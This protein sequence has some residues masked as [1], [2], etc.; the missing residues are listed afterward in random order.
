[1][2]ADPQVAFGAVIGD[3]S[4]EDQEFVD[5]F[6][7]GAHVEE[8][9]EP[10][11]LPGP[12]GRVGEPD[13][14]VGDR[15]G[16]RPGAGR[17]VLDDGGAGEGGS[18]RW[19]VVD[20]DAGEDAGQV[21]LGEVLGA[22]GRGVG[23]EPRPAAQGADRVLAGGQQPAGGG[24]AANRN[25]H[26]D[27]E[28]RPDEREGANQ[29]PLLS[30]DRPE[31]RQARQGEGAELRAGE[32]EEPADAVLGVVGVDSHR[33]APSRRGSDD[34]DSGFAGADLTGRNTGACWC[35]SGASGGS[36]GRG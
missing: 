17:L 36:R 30:V 28:E 35:S 9:S 7:T 26:K 6:G 11:A 29:R 8:V 31:H 15:A 22:T 27:G 5:E 24:T 16:D 33:G 2:L 20:G 32:A 21:S 12:R 19:A 10:G 25:D 1:M 3:S 14:G 34:E 13:A 23:A 18:L 4:D